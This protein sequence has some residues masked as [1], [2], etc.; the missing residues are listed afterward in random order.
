MRERTTL[1][2]GHL[3]HGPTA[4]GG[5]RVQLSIPRNL[6]GARAGAGVRAGAGAG[7]IDA[8]G[9]AAAAAQADLR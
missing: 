9:E 3:E 5:W 8:A 1:V 6:T 7:A 4:D 2:G